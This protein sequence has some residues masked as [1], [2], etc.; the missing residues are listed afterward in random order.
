MQRSGRKGEV[1][2][3]RPDVQVQI[4]ETLGDAVGRRTPPDQL[5]DPLREVDA[6]D[7]GIRQGA[8]DPIEARLALQERELRAASRTTSAALGLPIFPQLARRLLPPFPDQLVGERD[9]LGNVRRDQLLGPPDRGIEGPHAQLAFGDVQNDAVARAQA[10]LLP[11]PCRDD[12]PAAGCDPGVMPRHSKLPSPWLSGP[13]MAHRK[14]FDN[15]RRP[16][17]G[18]APPPPADQ[19]QDRAA[20]SSRAPAGPPTPT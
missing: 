16:G 2:I 10:E 5:G 1:A 20:M 4:A 19:L 11:Q 13:H 6:A 15:R 14:D 8:A 18:D 9:A 7:A 3:E 12:D 17:C